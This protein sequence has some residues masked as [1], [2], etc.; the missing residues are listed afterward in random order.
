[1]R[2]L[3]LSDIHAN[4]EALEAVF[5]D[6]QARSGFDVI[7]CLG[8][9]VGYG[10]DP[11]ACIDRIREFEL[12]AVAGNHDC[13][14][15]GLIDTSDFNDAARAAAKWTA[16][17]VDAGQRDYLTSLPMVSVQ[18][19]FTLVHGSLRE[20]IAEYLLDRNSAAGT[21]ALLETRYCLVGHSHIPF[22]CREVEGGAEF[23]EFPEGEPVALGDQR[24]IIN[25]GGVGQP[26]DRDPRPSY[27]V[28][29]T[30]D[31]VIERHRVTY[32]I[33]KT[34]EKMRAVDLPVHLIERLDHGI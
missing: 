26:R 12:V 33:A 18:E 10:P 34:Q 19:P 28:Y 32:D 2:A 27:A 1:M 29:D 16:G 15:V 23:T 21:L 31:I 17:Q 6:A 22:I 11:G 9:T 8:D 30:V 14:A 3:I 5:A 25:P 7:W 13:A 24:Q 20:P 4:L